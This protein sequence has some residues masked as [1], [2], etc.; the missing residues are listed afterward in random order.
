M[1]DKD[2]GNSPRSL[3]IP[4]EAGTPILYRYFIKRTL[5]EKQ[6]FTRRTLL[7]KAL[8]CD[9]VPASAGMTGAF[10]NPGGKRQDP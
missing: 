1:V 8:I 2:T 3:V 10:I 5:L 6:D 4:A 9:G 7:A